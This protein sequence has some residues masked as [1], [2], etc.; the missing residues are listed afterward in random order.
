MRGPVENARRPIDRL[1]FVLCKKQFVPQEL[2]P[3]P[4]S[5]SV[6][7]AG[8]ISHAGPSTIHSN[9]IQETG[10]LV[11]PSSLLQPSIVAYASEFTHLAQ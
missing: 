10:R 5:A 4:R 9:I 11:R 3:F 1:H 8:F 6:C 2:L 7:F